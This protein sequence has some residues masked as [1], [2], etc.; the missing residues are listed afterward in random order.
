MPT[1]LEKLFDWIGYTRKDKAAVPE[2]YSSPTSDPFTIWAS[3]KKISPDKAIEVYSGWVY[4]CI[5]AIAEE[6]GSIDF[7]LFRVGEDQDEEIHEHELLDLLFGVNPDQTGLELMY[8]TAGHL[9]A[10]GN[11]YW[12]LEGVKSETDKPT[13]IYPIIPNRVKVIVNR[14]NFPAHIE[15]Y[16]YRDRETG[17]LYHFKRHEILHFKYPDLTDPYEGLG[18]V[19]AI[20]Q[21]I[22]A[23]NYAMEFNRRFFLNGARLGGFLES[24]SAY[25]PEQLDYLKKSFEAIFKGVENA[26]RIAALPK[27][28]KFTPATEGQKDMDFNNLMQVMRD[29]NLAG[30]RVPRTALG[31]TDDVNRANAEATNYVFA[32]RTI[33]PKMRFITSYLNEF[34]VPRYG[35]DIYLGFVDPVPEDRM[36]RIEE[37]KA[38]TAGAPVMSPNEAREEYFGL[39]PVEGGDE[40]QRP[41]SLLA[42]GKPKPKAINKPG[43]K[44]GSRKLSRFARAARKRAEIGKAMADKLS[45]GIKQFNANL[46]KVK[47]KIAAS[48]SSVATLTDEEYETIWKAFVTRV[49][50]YYKAELEAVQKFNADQKKE[51]LKN[52]PDAIK[53][54]S[55]AERKINKTDLFDKGS[56]IAALVDLSLPILGD[57]MSKEGKEAATLLGIEDFDVMTPAVKEAL[58]RSINLMSTR[59]NETTLN[60]LKE[61]L[62]QG[63]S[64][65]L[66]LVELADL[67]EGIYEFSDVERA[68]VVAQTETFRVAN[69]ATKETWK[70]SG[71][72]KTIKWYTAADERVCPYCAPLHGKVIGIDEN[73]FNKGDKVEGGKNPPLVIEYDDIGTPPLHPS[74]RCYTRPEEIS[75]E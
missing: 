65:G 28:T 49:S 34:L 11:A 57:L 6:I 36:R 39:D 32:L 2:V 14:E 4:A 30:F 74:C 20:A 75:I 13:A 55:G 26:H 50:P 53:G 73:F 24:E 60:M 51:V 17:K 16:D 15:S 46:E 35:N 56:W 31:I 21:W 48:A 45:E 62:E 23:D 9:E 69:E 5:R 19:Q 22:D 29:R 67:V 38:S 66:S 52:L 8:M 33:K 63:I 61:K 18:T 3:H 1:F 7:Q 25:T 37:M 54:M 47:Q 42:L 64:E 41:F 12:Y 68:T 40:L 58:E 59:Y 71:F 44:N 10:V 27:G 72:V 43:K 70:Q